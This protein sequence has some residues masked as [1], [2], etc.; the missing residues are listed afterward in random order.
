MTHLDEEKPPGSQQKIK[1]GAGATIRDVIQAVISGQVTGD[2]HI[3]DK[4]YTRSSLEELNDYLARAVAKYEAR[5]NRAERRQPPPDHPY[6]FLYAFGLQDAGIFFGRDAA[7]EAL[8]EKVL[9][10][11]LTVLH[12]RSGAGKT[13]L[14]NAGLSPLLI[15]KDRLPVYARTYNDPT[16]AV[17]RA[18]APP[19]LGPWPELLPTLSLHEF[20]GLVCI[21]LEHQTQDL[22]VIFDQFE[23]FF[24]LLPEPDS[25]QP[26]ACSAVRKRH[27]HETRG[28]P[29]SASEG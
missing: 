26:F 25:R 9:K 6:K 16:L 23:E 22:V 17:K 4:V 5:M 15:K 3:G 21:Y 11:R 27:Q 24:V 29:A 19:S 1:A 20:L 10:D 8:Y 7:S 2:V 12:A 14:L 28:L 18:V 13:S